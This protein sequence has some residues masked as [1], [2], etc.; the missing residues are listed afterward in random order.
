MHTGRYALLFV[1]KERGTWDFLTYVMANGSSRCPIIL[2]CSKKDLPPGHF[3]MP[4]GFAF[5]Q[6][7]LRF[8]P[9]EYDLLAGL[10]ERGFP[11]GGDKL[12]FAFVIANPIF[13]LVFRIKNAGGFL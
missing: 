3:P 1:Q 9:V 6:R 2:L 10:E 11:D 5:L 7:A 4:G 13:V 8:D 12:A